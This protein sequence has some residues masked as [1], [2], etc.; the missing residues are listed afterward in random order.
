MVARSRGRECSEH[1][2]GLVI[3]RIRRTLSLA[4]MRAQALC[5]QNRLANLGD[6]AGEAA[7]I[8]EQ[9]RLEKERAAGPPLAT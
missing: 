8:R 6:G 1:E 9:L 5:L 4:I 7:R 3:G 2:L